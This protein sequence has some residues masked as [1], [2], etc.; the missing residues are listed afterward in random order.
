MHDKAAELMRLHALP[1]LLILVNVWDVA[2]ARAV[3]AQPGCRAIATAS[4]AIAA[5]HGY[6]DGE[7]IPPRLMFEMID[8]IAAAVDLRHEGCCI[9][10]DLRSLRSI[11]RQRAHVSRRRAATVLTSIRDDASH[12]CPNA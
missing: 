8:R 12:C 11:K 9:C 3:A 10:G 1:E 2:S 7:R 6:P 5:A 4:A